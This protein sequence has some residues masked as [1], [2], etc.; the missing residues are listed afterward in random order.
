[1]KD[2]KLIGLSLKKVKDNQKAKFSYVN[3]STKKKEFAKVEE[4]KFSDIDFEIDVT[5]GTKDGMQ[6]GGYVLFGNYDFIWKL[7]RKKRRSL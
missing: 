7:S 4:V 5:T 3:M 1:M 6:Q 2:K